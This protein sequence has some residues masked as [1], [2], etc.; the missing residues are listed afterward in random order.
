MDKSGREVIPVKYGSMGN[1]VDGLAKVESDEKWGYIDKSDQ[2]VIPVKYD[3]AWDFTDGGAIMKLNGKYGYIDISGKEIIPFEYDYMWDFPKLIWAKLNDK[4]KRFDRTGKMDKKSYGPGL[5]VE[6]KC[7]NGSN[8]FTVTIMDFFIDKDESGNTA[9]NTIGMGINWGSSVMFSAVEQVKCVIIS[10]GKE[11]PVKNINFRISSTSDI[12]GVPI[13]YIFETDVNP[14][15]VVF[16]SEQDSKGRV[17][18][19]VNK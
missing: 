11:Y 1:F 19:Q 17:S 12:S 10:K 8:T 15:T 3:Y 16:Y 5:P 9:V 2:E 7:Q 6:L 14:E 18:I 13:S 4:W